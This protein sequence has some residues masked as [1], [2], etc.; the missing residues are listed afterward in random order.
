MTE[1]R[2]RK[3]KKKAPSFGGN[4]A[5]AASGKTKGKTLPPPKILTPAGK[6]LGVV[7]AVLYVVALSV[8]NPITS[9]RFVRKL[10]ARSCTGICQIPDG[11]SD[12]DCG[13]VDTDRVVFLRIPKTAT[14][15]I[16]HVFGALASD[17]AVAVI[18][19]LELEDLTSSLPKP[20]AALTAQSYHDPDPRVVRRRV[21]AYYKHAT[22]EV[23]Y[24]PYHAQQRTLFEGHLYHFDWS[25]DA[26]K[27]VG[28]D[29]WW[30][31]AVPKFY[32]RLYGLERPTEEAMA[33]VHEITMV[34]KPQNRLASMYYYDRHDART[35]FWRREFVEARGNVTLEECLLDPACVETNEL[36]RWCSVQVELLCGLG[37]E[38]ARPVGKD[39]LQRAK[40]N[41]REKILF[42]GVVERMEESIGFMEKLLPTYLEGAGEIEELPRKK[43]STTI[44]RETSFSSKAQAVL[45]DICSLDNA[46]YQYVDSLLTERLRKCKAS[47]SS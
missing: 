12:A 4:P 47:A 38:C 44:R 16:K 18:D 13:P 42:A 14:T 40:E 2:Q 31:R 37:K 25:P 7:L 8:V 33:K 41:V 29:P 28:P 17:K 3:G 20:G 6:V 11:T 45:D 43:Q 26:L 36:G 32:E 24:P 10:F 30:K 21:Q 5:S 15:T 23:A 9:A 27:M 35:E 46:L 39:A 19:I 22:K 34:R 1:A